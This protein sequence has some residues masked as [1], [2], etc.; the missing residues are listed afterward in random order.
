M[1]DLVA[2]LLTLVRLHRDVGAALTPFDFIQQQVC[3]EQKFGE[4]LV[5]K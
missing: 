3:G 4:S 1:A 5:R 2:R